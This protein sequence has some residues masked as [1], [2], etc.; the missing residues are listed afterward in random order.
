MST[1][2]HLNPCQDNLGSLQDIYLSNCPGVWSGQGDDLNLEDLHF[3]N[4]L[5]RL[6]LDGLPL[7]RLLGLAQKQF[8]SDVN[9]VMLGRLTFVRGAF[10]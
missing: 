1:D 10:I 4:Q 7:K 3:C 6:T 5:H 8:R 9:R 2:F